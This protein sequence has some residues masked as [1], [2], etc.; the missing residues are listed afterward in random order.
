MILT[1]KNKKIIVI[2][3]TSFSKILYSFWLVC[4]IYKMYRPLFKYSSNIL[5][6]DDPFD[7]YI[8][9]IPISLTKYN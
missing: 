5:I 2:S 7:R 1:P 8:R 4:Q 3:M 6:T 9:I